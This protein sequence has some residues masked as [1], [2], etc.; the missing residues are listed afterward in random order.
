[1]TNF[2]LNRMLD[3]PAKETSTERCRCFG[4]ASC[5]RAPLGEITNQRMYGLDARFTR[6]LE[7]GYARDNRI[8]IQHCSAPVRGPTH[9]ELSNL[10]IS[11]FIRSI[12]IRSQDVK[13]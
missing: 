2:L 1:M 3:P 9:R 4:K 7:E 11:E 8:I 12:C 5:E 13:P 10:K 6:F